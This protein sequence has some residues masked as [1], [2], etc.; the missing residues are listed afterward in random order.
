ML[1]V[2]LGSVVAGMA[3]A[4]TSGIMTLA[5]LGLV[6]RPLALP[7]DAVLALFIVIDPVVGP[8]RAMTNVQMNLALSS[9]LAGRALPV[10]E[11]TRT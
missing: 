3:T 6:L 4:G 1:V 7:L 11:E 2:A 5:M 8:L 10:T 9:L